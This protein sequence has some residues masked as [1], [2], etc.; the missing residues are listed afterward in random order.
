M[1]QPTWYRHLLEKAVL[2][3]ASYKMNWVEFRFQSKLLMRCQMAWSV[4]IHIGKMSKIGAVALVRLGKI[5]EKASVE[6]H[7]KAEDKPLIN[8]KLAA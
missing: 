4:L 5:L 8:G 1:F 2:I 7:E 6:K 3:S